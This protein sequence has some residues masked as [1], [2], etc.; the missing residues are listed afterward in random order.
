M[1][2]PNGSPIAP[3]ARRSKRRRTAIIRHVASQPSSSS[4]GYN[5]DGHD[6]DFDPESKPADTLYSED[7]ATS[8][9][10]TLRKP[11]KSVQKTPRA[12]GPVV[13]QL[14]PTN[15]DLRTS[16][17]VKEI[18]ILQSKLLEWYVDNYRRLPWR[19]SPRYRKDGLP[20]DLIPTPKS[21]S[22]AGAPYAIWISEVMSQQTRIQV[23]VEYY[24]RWMREFPTVH[25]LANAS[26]D[27]VNEL[28]A[29]LG[30]YRR[31]RFLHEGAKQI[32]EKYG[33]NLPPDAASLQKLKGIGRYT[34]GAISSIAF[35]H[36]EPVVDGNVER[37]LSRLLPA[38]TEG[39]RTSREL[40]TNYW[41]VASS[42]VNGVKT[43]G[44]FNQSMM[45]LGATIC[46]PKNPECG[47]C[48]LQS[49]CGAYKAATEL[50]VEEPSQYVT[51]YPIKDPRKQTKV[52]EETVIVLVVCA[53]IGGVPKFLILQRPKEG[54]LA[55]L[56][57]AP[58]KVVTSSKPKE[59]VSVLDEL[60]DIPRD[61]VGVKD[62]IR[63][64]KCVDVRN[65]IHVFSHI[66]Q[67]LEVCLLQLP[68]GLILHAEHGTTSKAI[69][70]RW[71]S[72]ADM[73][74]SAISTQMRKVFAAATNRLDDC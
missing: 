23:V 47:L 45:E 54:L 37:V 18:T 16:F 71:L 36:A 65:V 6:S 35:G 46:K 28:W 17:D 59:K 51:R 68:D 74:D 21:P 5:T 19:P 55:N 44:D 11:R 25:D 33:G 73:N 2:W 20:P 70:F 15:P 53:T 7:F 56:W 12:K 31:A 43:P 3:S 9:P 32:V 10:P 8:T 57:E 1:V 22:S 67:T 61:L 72:S 29:G 42:C 4:E 50:A 66:R 30:Y 62:C 49:I 39:Q 41:S 58:N 13:S 26:L 34:A 14:K 24:N 69:P 63:R 40:L 27:R 48:P 38:L 52:R 60:L 64:E